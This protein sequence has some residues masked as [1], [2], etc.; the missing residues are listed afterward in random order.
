MDPVRPAAKK[1]RPWG[2]RGGSLP[3]LTNSAADQ[4]STIAQEAPPGSSIGVGHSMHGQVCRVAQDA[5]PLPRVAGQFTY[6][7]PTSNLVKPG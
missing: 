7:I 5:T 1:P 4:L 3:A 6:F 2:G